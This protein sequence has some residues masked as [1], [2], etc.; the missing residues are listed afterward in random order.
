MESIQRN[1]GKMDSTVSICFA[2]DNNYVA[3]LKVSIYS[4]LCNRDK[5]KY[6]D[7]IIL[8]TVITKQNREDVLKLI[9]EEENVAIRFIDL[10]EEE[11]KIKYEVGAYYSIATLYRLFLF[12]D[13]FKNYEKLLYLDCDLVVLED[14]SKLYNL[15]MQGMHIAAIED[16]GMK[17]IRYDANAMLPYNGGFVSGKRYCE[18]ILRLKNVENYFNAGVVLY[19]LNKCRETYSFAEVIDVLYSNNFV[20]NDQDTLNIIFEDK[21]KKVDCKWN[22]QNML[23]DFLMKNEGDYAPQLKAFKRNEYGIVHYVGEEKPW[24]GTVK[25]DRFY[26]QYADML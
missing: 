17:Q 25:L 23:D 5:S 6:Y 7:I 21:V 15:D 22:Y 4:L 24:N 26:H 8:H 2:C 10:T 14:I 3:C 13:L 9:Q 19:D 12:T 18:N 1:S 16:I 11:M 20:F